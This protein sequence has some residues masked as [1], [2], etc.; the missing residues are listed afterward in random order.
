M[1]APGPWRRRPWNSLAV[2]LAL[3]LVV[4]T[5]AL[6]SLFGYLNLRVQRQQSEEL[7]L[8]SAERISDL[9]RRSTH[10]QMLRNDREALYQV[11]RTIGNEPGIRRIRIFNEEGRISLSTDPTEVGKLVDKHAE[12]CYG[13][14]AQQAPLTRLA[15]KD[16]ARTFT[17]AQGDRVLGVIRPIENEPVCS[18]A[19]C[20]AH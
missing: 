19:A 3:A 1:E 6:F 2:K 9:I 11:I 17:D 5:A 20:H 14:H 8:V 13:C 4:S 15:R 18:N 10:Y 7:V 16:R 12:A